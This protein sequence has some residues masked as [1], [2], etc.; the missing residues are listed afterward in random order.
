M[1]KIVL[2]ILPVFLLIFLG[3]L[4]RR[5][6]FPGEGFWAPAERLTYFLLLPSLI[7]VTLAEADLAD[8]AVLPMVLALAAAI[9]LMSLEAPLAW[10]IVS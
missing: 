4:C 1:L 10:T 6:A 8:L 7:V 3:H 9:V 5:R 2:V